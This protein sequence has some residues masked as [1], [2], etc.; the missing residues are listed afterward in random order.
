MHLLQDD[1][2]PRQ[3]AHEQ[4]VRRYADPYLARRSGGRKHPVEDFLFTYYT[5]KPGQLLRWHPGAGVMLSGPAAAER[6]GWKHYRAANDGELAAAGL[7]P[8]TAAVTVDVDAFLLGRGEALKFAGIILAGTAA[9][10]AQFG[11]FGLH[12]WAM[13]YRQDKFELRHEYLRLRLGADHTDQVVEENRI[14]CS[15]FDAFRFYTPDAVPLNSLEPSRDNQRTMEQPGCLHANMDLYKWAYKLAPVLPSELVMDCFE[16]SWR[17]RA[18]DMRASPYDLA[19]W[20]Y[21]AIRI[22]TPEGKADYVDRQRAFAAESQELR[23]RMLREISPLLRVLGPD[24]GTTNPRTT[25]RSAG[26]P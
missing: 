5:Q 21:P 13:V 6:T 15:H 16:L 12:E 24:T 19:E 8:G 1:W 3:A 25:S 14:R 4:R 2:L 10:P 18:M 11:C 22:E 9:R 17:I 23:H 26:Q 20:G 7:P